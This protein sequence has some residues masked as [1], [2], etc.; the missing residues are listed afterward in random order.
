MATSSQNRRYTS[1][2][3]KSRPPAGADVLGAGTLSITAGGDYAFE[4]GTDLLKKLVLRRLITRPGEFR[5]IPAFGVGLA[6]KEPLP[7]GGDL[8]K[9]RTAIEGQVMKEP[10]VEDVKAELILDPNAGSLTLNLRVKVRGT[11][12]SVSIGPVV[13]NNPNGVQ[14]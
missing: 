2:D 4:E 5:H 11:G 8:L 7:A 6:I 3:V 12:Q 9:L 1:R 13:L 14:L 10:E